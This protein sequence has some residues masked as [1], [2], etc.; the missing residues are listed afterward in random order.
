MSFWSRIANLITGGGA[1]GNRML[2]IYVLSK[3][4]NEPIAGQV[5]LFN[6]L[7]RTEDDNDYTFFTRKVLHTSGENR[8]FDQVEV[9]LWFDR[10]KK[11]ADHSVDGGRWLEEEEYE[12][13][14]VRFRTPPDEEQATG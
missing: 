12:A 1:S 10:N 14:L 4:C 2:N 11:V 8:C 9:N 3:R 5:D 7:S 13:E 6:E